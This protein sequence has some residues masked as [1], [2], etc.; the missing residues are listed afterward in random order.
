MKEKEDHDRLY[1]AIKSCEAEARQLVSEHNESCCVGQTARLVAG[2]MH[3]LAHKIAPERGCGDGL[4]APRR[5]NSGP[6]QV[7]TPAY[8]ENWESI[9]GKKISPGQA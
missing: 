9:F 5:E 7:A 4:G 8:R 2:A 1:S 3:G 6:A